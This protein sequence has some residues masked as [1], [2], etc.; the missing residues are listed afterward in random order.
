MVYKELLKAKNYLYQLRLDNPDMDAGQLTRE[1][2][3][4]IDLEIDKL[5]KL[6]NKERALELVKANPIKKIIFYEDGS[7]DADAL[8]E[9]I[10]VRNPDM[11]MVCYRQGSD[12]PEIVNIED[13]VGG[14]K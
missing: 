11:L 7:I 14:E 5:Q 12:R 2:G 1:F 4:Y 8:G 3:V 9:A 6:E 10:E 13:T